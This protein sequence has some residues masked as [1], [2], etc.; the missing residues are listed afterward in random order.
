MHIKSSSIYICFTYS[1]LYYRWSNSI[2]SKNNWAYPK[3]L[4]I[5]LCA[6]ETV[7]TCELCGGPKRVG[8]KIV[9]QPTFFKFSVGFNFFFSSHPY[10]KYEC[11]FIIHQISLSAKQIYVTLMPIYF[12][13]FPM[14]CIFWLDIKNYF[15]LAESV[16]SLKVSYQIISICF[17]SLLKC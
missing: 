6:A 10:W 9:K 14:K 5:F 15:Y 1:K 3:F 2:I 7:R 13:S 16:D 17:A 11:S 8:T 12:Q 4:A